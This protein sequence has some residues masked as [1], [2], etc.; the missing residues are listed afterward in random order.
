M[1]NMNIKK[2]SGFAF[3][4][5]LLV[6]LLSLSACSLFHKK[7]DNAADTGSP[8]YLVL[9]EDLRQDREKSKKDDYLPLP[10]GT[11]MVS[12]KSD[13]LLVPPGSAAER[14][15]MMKKVKKKTR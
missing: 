3:S 8:R 12:D 2:F 9:P 15:E 10:P 11:Q 4:T 1:K 13:V 6:L 5:A 14:K 7:S